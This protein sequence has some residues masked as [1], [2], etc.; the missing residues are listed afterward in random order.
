MK[1][2]YKSKGLRRQILRQV[3]R[4]EDGKEKTVTVHCLEGSQ[5]G[6][7][8]A[9][10]AG[11]HGM[12]HMGSVVLERFLANPP[13]DFCGTLFVCPCANPFALELDYEWYPE[14]EGLEPL[15]GYF[16]SKF[17]HE[18]C[19][20]GIG[21]KT[22]QN[23][24]RVWNRRHEPGMGLT[25]A[26]TSWIWDTALAP[27][28]LIVDF[29]ARNA[30]RP[31]VYTCGSE[32]V[33]YTRYFGAQGV[34]ETMTEIDPESFEGGNLAIQ[35]NLGDKRTFCLEYSI[36]HGVRH[37]EI[38]FG[39]NGIINTM[40]GIG[41]LDGDVILERPVYKMTGLV[42]VVPKATGHIHYYPEPY[43]PVAAGDLIFEVYSLETLEVIDR[44][45]APVGGYM[46]ERYHP[47]IASP[48]APLCSV[49]Q[50]EKIA[51][52]GKPLEKT[53]LPAPKF[54]S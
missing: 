39:L 35:G 7:V 29:H 46:S 18:F 47:P 50:G 24:N 9:L 17:R 41:M 28:D 2:S 23:M 11:Q 16:Y 42:P 40:K 4:A 6:P 32:I 10:I 12:E 20:Y 53:P 25:G 22:N 49:M 27:A 43:E 1:T 44:G 48:G 14:K 54:P 5:P 13:P 37:E 30:E 21:R 15:D 33:P 51:E 52:A 34:F 31:L 8:L 36:Q 3:F 19:P 38:P 45:I 26:I